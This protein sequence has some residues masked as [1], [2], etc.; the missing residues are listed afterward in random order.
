MIRA[1]FK[2]LAAVLATLC[3]YGLALPTMMSSRSTLLCLFGG[4]LALVYPV[5]VYWAF[6]TKKFMKKEKA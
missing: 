6:T 2:L 1:Y 3:T 5:G 4:V